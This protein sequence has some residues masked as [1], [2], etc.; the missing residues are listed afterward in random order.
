MKQKKIFIVRGMDCASCA[1]T[2]EK[3]LKEIPELS[4]ANVNYATEKAVVESDGPIDSFRLQSAVKEKTGY[5]LIEERTLPPGHE[6]HQ[7]NRVQMP[8]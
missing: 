4:S 3:A 7:M 1:L 6:G 2:I 8:G 5:E